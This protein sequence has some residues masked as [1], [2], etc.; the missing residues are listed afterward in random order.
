MTPRGRMT[1]GLDIALERALDLSI[2]A[3]A[4]DPMLAPTVTL[5]QLVITTVFP[6]LTGP[7]LTGSLAKPVESGEDK[8]ASPKCPSFNRSRGIAAFLN[9]F[10]VKPV[11]LPRRA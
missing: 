4:H 11:P 6:R 2:R 7:R 3:L 5:S 10:S 1:P 9:R 8:R